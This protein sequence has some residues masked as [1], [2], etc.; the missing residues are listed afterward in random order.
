MVPLSRGGGAKPPL[1][2]KVQCL[3]REM[4]AVCDQIRAIDKSRLTDWIKEMAPEDL[5][6]IGQ[7]LKQVLALS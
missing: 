5:A 1:T 3:G 6:R 7:A 4:R 2:V